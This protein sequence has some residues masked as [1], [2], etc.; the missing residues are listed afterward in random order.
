[1]GASADLRWGPVDFVDGGVRC[2]EGCAGNRSANSIGGN[3][4]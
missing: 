4:N 2:R 3:I 1:M